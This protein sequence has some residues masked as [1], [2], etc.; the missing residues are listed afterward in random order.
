MFDG[1]IN[2]RLEEVLENKNQVTKAL[3]YDVIKIEELGLRPLVTNTTVGPA[4]LVV[5]Q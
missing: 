1:A 5:G 2:V 3:Q 4:G